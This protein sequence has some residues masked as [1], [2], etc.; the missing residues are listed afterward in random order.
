MME[1]DIMEQYTVLLDKRKKYEAS[2]P[3]PKCK[4][5]LLHH[6]I[7]NGVRFVVGPQGQ[8]E[9]VWN[10]DLC[11]CPGCGSLVLTDFGDRPQY[12]YNNLNPDNI[13]DWFPTLSALIEDDRKRGNIIFFSWQFEKRAAA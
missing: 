8:P 6:Y 3:C 10:A 5:S 12:T 9:E 2:M 4:T 1:G 7:K 13:P 11:K